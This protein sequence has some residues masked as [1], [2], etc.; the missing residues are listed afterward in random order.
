MYV[1]IS[2]FLYIYGVLFLP[3]PMIPVFCNDNKVWTLYSV[4]VFVYSIRTYLCTVYVCIF[5]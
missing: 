5:I 2:V 3:C 1:Y 4:P